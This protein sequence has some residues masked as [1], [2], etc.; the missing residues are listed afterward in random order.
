MTPPHLLHSLRTL[1][2]SSSVSIHPAELLH[3]S[4]S[5]SESSLNCL[6]EAA[7]SAESVVL[8]LSGQGVRSSGQG[9][10]NQKHSRAGYPCYLLSRNTM[11]C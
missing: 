2:R 8:G 5:S 11:P 10:V 7:K 4:R 6:S 9:V 3:A 1:H